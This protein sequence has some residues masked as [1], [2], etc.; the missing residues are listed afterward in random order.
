MNF[1][2][3]IYRDR[4]AVNT[5]AELIMSLAYQGFTIITKSSTI[6]HNMIYRLYLAK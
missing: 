2:H 6:R 5:V 1:R 4:V 3:I